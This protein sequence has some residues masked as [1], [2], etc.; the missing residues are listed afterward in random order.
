[1]TEFNERVRAARAEV[2][3]RL[4]QLQLEASRQLQEHLNLL[5]AGEPVLPLTKEQAAR[6]AV[7]LREQGLP[8]SSIAAVMRVY[9]G[10]DRSEATWRHACRKRGIPGRHYLNGNERR[11]IRGD[12]DA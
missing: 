12:T 6:Q 1:M 11:V 7:R 2:D 5:R 10:H 3:K 8:Y 4:L 9:H